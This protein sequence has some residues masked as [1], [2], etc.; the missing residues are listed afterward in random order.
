LAIASYA[1]VLV[2]FKKFYKVKLVGGGDFRCHVPAFS[3]IMLNVLNI[4]MSSNHKTDYSLASWYK[5]LS[6]DALGHP[7]LNKFLKNL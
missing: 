6:F 2:Y 3:I 7:S 1:L 5:V 4:I